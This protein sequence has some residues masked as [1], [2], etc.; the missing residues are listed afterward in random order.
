M[1]LDLFL[2][3]FQ[4]TAEDHAPS[5]PAV[6]HTGDE[7]VGEIVS[8]LGGKTFNHGIYRILRS[9]QLYA[10]KEVMDR[11]FPEYAGTMQPFAYD[12]LGRHFAL[13]LESAEPEILLLEVGVGEA[14]TIPV[15]IEE[16]H[17]LELTQYTNDSLASDYWNS[18]RGIH[19]EALLFSDCVGYKIPLFLGGEDELHNL[20]TSDMDVYLEFCAQLREKT[21]GLPPGTKISDISFG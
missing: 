5:S 8:L 10:A 19:P 18:W 7:Q 12:W 21:R 9:D 1:N 3:A 6:K 16:F 20:E 14:L 15:T 11:L 13:V 2:K 4:C 17:N